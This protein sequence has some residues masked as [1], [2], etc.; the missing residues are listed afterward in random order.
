MDGWT[1]A[2]IAIL[3]FVVGLFSIYSALVL[4]AMR[5]A[6]RAST[7]LHRLLTEDHVH[8]AEY[9]RALEYFRVEISKVYTAVEVN[10]NRISKLEAYQELLRNGRGQAP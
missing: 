1:G 4:L 2:D 6:N 10:S 8:R 5:S 7:E 3:S 9:E